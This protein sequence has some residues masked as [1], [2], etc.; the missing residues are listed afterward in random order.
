MP[1]ETGQP[2]VTRDRASVTQIFKIGQLLLVNAVKFQG[3]CLYA[4]GWTDQ[5]IA[6]Q[7]KCSLPS[8]TNIRR[9]LYGNLHQSSN[10]PVEH[11]TI[12]G[13]KFQLIQVAETK[14]SD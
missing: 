6:D 13:K 2:K 3:K 14:P 1:K 8:V 11:I 9:Q 7:V 10:G 5:R 12:H 4:D